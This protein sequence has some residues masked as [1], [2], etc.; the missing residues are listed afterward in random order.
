[1]GHLIRFIHNR[2]LA[3]ENICTAYVRTRLLLS[4]HPDVIASIKSHFKVQG[5][6]LPSPSILFMP[7][8]TAFQLSGYFGVNLL[9]SRRNSRIT[10]MTG[11]RQLQQIHSLCMSRRGG[12]LKKPHEEK[13]CLRQINDV[14]LNGVVRAIK[15]VRLVLTSV[16]ICQHVLTP[17]N[18][19]VNI[20]KFVS[21]DFPLRR[22]SQPLVRLFSRLLLGGTLP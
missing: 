14:V 2:D 7:E 4:T 22:S 10:D 3:V 17:V 13:E 6:K 19:G 1:M 16:N 8:Q 15:Q 9:P 12:I 21:T 11:T 5:C 20:C 18:T